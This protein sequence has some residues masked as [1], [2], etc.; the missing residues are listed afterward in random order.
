MNLLQ[1]LLWPLRKKLF[2]E[3]WCHWLAVLAV[4]GT[5]VC[6]FYAIAS[7][8]RYFFDNTVF[9]GAAAMLVL[10]MSFAVALL[11][12]P[13]WEET[14]KEADKLGYD[15]RFVT[16]ME[17]LGKKEDLTHV[18]KL[19][20]E[21]ACEK[22]KQHLI[23][24]KYAFKFP[25]KQMK[26]FVILLA[27]L[28]STHFVN[29]K[30]QLEA[31]RYSMAQLK[32]IEAVKKEVKNTQEL[33]KALL[34]TFEK[35]MDTAEKRL[36][37]AQTLQEGQK[38]V[39]QAQQAIKELEKNSV[40]HDLK[41]MAESFSQSEKTKELA[42]A[43]EEGNSSDIKN[44]MDRLLSDVN[45]MSWQEMEALA[46]LLQN[47]EDLQQEELKEL[48]KD[49]A[50]QLSSGDFSQI[51]QQGQLLKQKLSSLAT[52]GQSLQESL[53][54][55][56][57]AL[58]EASLQSSASQ[59]GTQEQKDTQQQG[60]G[61]GNGQGEEGK[62]Q[63]QMGGGQ[64][65]G[66]NPGQGRGEGHKESENIFTRKAQQMAGYE[67]QLQGQQLQ[68]GQTTI[69]SQKTTGQRGESIP[70]EQVYHSYRNEALKD[71][72]NSD[73]PYGM[74]ELVSQYFSTLEQ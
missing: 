66:E 28:A 17:L 8:W 1:K 18:E 69:I 65:Q 40:S 71:M 39:E 32:K 30:R 43:L 49:F 37:K 11:K 14:A 46:D 22:A 53:Q 62:G 54:Q 41:K 73:V 15:E 72:E 3:L 56:N 19:V 9:F 27:V 61:Q 55:F 13:S 44:N 6:I 20:I 70:Y 48:A 45:E 16:A 57:Q 38:A 29:T 42:S 10:I 4:I 23:Q 7:K 34:D 59:T 47:I 24:K 33:D 63:Q 5:G 12:C 2:L 51:W 68:N 36:K 67:A 26:Q 52:E 64:G 35:E 74:R 50:K 25:K 58:A 21:D 60:M 31:E